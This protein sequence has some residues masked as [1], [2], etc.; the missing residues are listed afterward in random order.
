MADDD[1]L[2][3]LKELGAQPV[4]QPPSSQSAQ[5]QQPATPQQQQ[6]AEEDDALRELRGLAPQPATAEPSRE[7]ASSYVG[8]VADIPGDISQQ[9]T[10]GLKA[11]VKAPMKMAGVAENEYADLVPRMIKLGASP[12]V[13]QEMARRL[14]TRQGVADM[15]MGP[16]QAATS[17]IWGPIRSMVSRPVEETTG[18]PKE[19]TEAGVGLLMGRPRMVKPGVASPMTS[20]LFNTADEG[21][22]VARSLPIDI[23]PQTVR[24]IADH[25]EQ[26]LWDKHGFRENN[27]GPTLS[28]L[29]YLREP[30]AGAFATMSDVNSV[31]QNLG[32]MARQIDA[33]GHRTPNAAAASIAKEYLGEHLNSLSE[34]DTLRGGHLLPTLKEELTKA[35]QNYGAAIRSDIVDRAIEMAQRQAGKAGAGAN[36]ENALR[37]RFASILNSPKKAQ[38]YNAQELRMMD[39]FVKGSTAQNAARLFGKMAPTGIVSGAGSV[40]LGAMLGLPLEALPVTG[41]VSKKIADTRAIAKAQAIRE[42]IARRSPLFLEAQGA[43]QPQFRMNA[44]PLLRFPSVDSNNFKKGGRARKSFRIPR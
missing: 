31:Q 10:E 27:A 20:R 15:L 44:W 13:A 24:D 4:E 6:P 14:Q 37:Q 42:Q 2:S 9:F 38:R 18:V 1:I 7:Q 26:T 40:G 17:W 41:Y 43:A 35:N 33:D 28:A 3:E 25:I 19:L 30:K 22:T 8:R 32:R 36:I 39:E 12:A 34:A 29:E 21:Y 16:I 11:T 23:K 5:Q